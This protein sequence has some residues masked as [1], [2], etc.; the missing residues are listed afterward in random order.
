M[1]SMTFGPIGMLYRGRIRE[2]ALQLNISL[3]ENKGLVTSTYRATGADRAVKVMGAML[4][5]MVE[6]IATIDHRNYVDDMEKAEKR[7]AWWGSLIGRRVRTA[8]FT[9][10]ESDGIF[11]LLCEVQWSGSEMHDEASD[12]LGRSIDILAPMLDRKTTSSETLSTIADVRLRYLQHDIRR[13]DIRVPAD[14]RG[15]IMAI[16]P[17]F[18]TWG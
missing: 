6:N 5:Q 17:N 3:T 9:R 4:Q 1:A 14:L 13:G 16:K 12:R 7:R 2:I 11:L 18:D 15:R 8:H 10:E